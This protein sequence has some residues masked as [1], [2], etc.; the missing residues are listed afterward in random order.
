MLPFETPETIDSRTGG[1]TFESV[2]AGVGIYVEAHFIELPLSTF[3]LGSNT[4][5]GPINP[6]D[7]TIGSLDDV[8]VMDAGNGM[9]KFEVYNSMDTA[10][11][12]RIPG[13]NNTVLRALGRNETPFGFG[14]QYAQTF[15]WTESY[16]LK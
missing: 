9:V 14:G 12:T 1:S 11:L 13:S 3:G 5:G 15:S 6:V 10:S 4:P 16:P 2:L 7:G 8:S